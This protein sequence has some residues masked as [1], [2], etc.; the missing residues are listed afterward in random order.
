[1]AIWHYYNEDGE[2]V[3]PVTD[4]QLKT[5]A[6]Q[7]I[8]LPGTVLETE[9]GTTGQAKDVVGL[10][11]TDSVLKLTPTLRPHNEV[12]VVPPDAGDVYGLTLP[13]PPKPSDGM[14]STL[15]LETFVCKT[16]VSFVEADPFVAFVTEVSQATPLQDDAST[17]A[18]ETLPQVNSLPNVKEKK[19]RRWTIL[20]GLLLLLTVAVI[21]LIGLAMMSVT[22]NNQVLPVLP[23]TPPRQQQRQEADPVESALQ[24]PVHFSY[25]WDILLSCTHSFIKTAVAM[26]DEG[27]SKRL[28][29]QSKHPPLCPSERSEPSKE[30]KSD[31]SNRPV[32]K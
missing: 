21:G 9:E 27:S 8:V 7:G 20:V 31:N 29:E 32:R 3:G 12:G 10:T 2:R 13:P 19:A 28:T 24:Q 22:T 25:R 17:E 1:M 30:S 23:Q 6:G 26:H 15:V 16:P 14:N 5:L 4:K 18:E 11:F